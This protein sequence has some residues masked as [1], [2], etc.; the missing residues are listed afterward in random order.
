MRR[1]LD[2]APQDF[3]GWEWDH[4]A[5]SI[6][7]ELRSLPLELRRHTRPVVAPDGLHAIAVADDASVARVISV[8][9]HLV[10]T[11]FLL[12]VLKRLK[13]TLRSRESFHSP[14]LPTQ[15]PSSPR[16][17]KGREVRPRQ[18]P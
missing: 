5:A 10:N 4:L 2:L 14:G 3:R 13:G 17:G 9:I 1:R 6:E 15:P 8:P 7:G 18:A 16:E 11:F 12:S